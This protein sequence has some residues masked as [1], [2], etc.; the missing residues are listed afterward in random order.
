MFATTLGTAYPRW[1]G[2]SETL[3]LFGLSEPA[4]AGPEPQTSAPRGSELT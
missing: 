1:T 4:Q 3:R 2:H